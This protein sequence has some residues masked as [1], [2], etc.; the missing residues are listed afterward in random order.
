MRTR[1]KQGFMLALLCSGSVLSGTSLQT[2]S[3]ELDN[4]ASIDFND[5][6]GQWLLIAYWATWCGPCREEI[7]MLNSIHRQRDELNVVVLGINFDGVQGEQ[8]ASEKARFNSEFPDLLK[9]PHKVWDLPRPDFIPRILVVNP[10]GLME[11][12][13]VGSTTRRKLMGYLGQ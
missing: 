10:E 11:A 12:I 9:D 8:L 13:I 2:V 3:F 5:A 7:R 6:K 1:V 4:G